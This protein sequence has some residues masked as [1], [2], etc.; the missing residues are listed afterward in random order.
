MKMYKCE[1]FR[2]FKCLIEPIKIIKIRMVFFFSTFSRWFG[3]N[4]S[5][6]A[7]S[8]LASRPLRLSNR[9]VIWPTSCTWVL[10]LLASWGLAT[11]FTRLATVSPKVSFIAVS[12]ISA[13]FSSRRTFSFLSNRDTR[14]AYRIDINIIVISLSEYTISTRV[15]SQHT[16]KPNG[17]YLFLLQVSDSVTF[18]L[19]RSSR[20]PLPA[21]MIQKSRLRLGRG[22][23]GRIRRQAGDVRIAVNGR[24]WNVWQ[25]HTR[26]RWHRRGM[27]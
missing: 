23:V 21:E 22:V 11:A 27:N 4:K 3:S 16:S 6:K 8:T 2:M 26:R 25:Q 18:R 13:I 7:F 19:Q 9:L 17:F 24:K 5:S 20:L 10:N 12:S 1:T 15:R 14:S